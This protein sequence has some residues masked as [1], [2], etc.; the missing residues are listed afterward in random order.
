MTVAELQ[1]HLKQIPN[2]EKVVVDLKVALFLSDRDII[3]KSS[4]TKVRVD[5]N[6]CM[7]I[8]YDG[9]EI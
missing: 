1:T 3:C 5:H 7:L 4:I 8:G 6:K 2:P 9:V